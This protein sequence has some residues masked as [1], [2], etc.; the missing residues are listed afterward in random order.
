MTE[1]EL[2]KRNKRLSKTCGGK[3]TRGS[4]KPP[5]S[6]RD[7]YARQVPQSPRDAAMRAYLRSVVAMDVLLAA[8]QALRTTCLR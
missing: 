3:V 1:R 8:L 5:I 4:L 2:V 7:K 6:K